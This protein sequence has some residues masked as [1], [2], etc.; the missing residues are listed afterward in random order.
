MAGI[1]PMRFDELFE[2]INVLDK[3]PGK[4]GKGDSF[5]LNLAIPA[6]KALLP[7]LQ[8]RKV[9]LLGQRVSHAFDVGQPILEWHERGFGWW[10]NDVIV[11]LSC[12]LAVCPHPS[13]VNTWWNKPENRIA[14]RVFWG[15]LAF[16]RQQLQ[17]AEFC[18][19]KLGEAK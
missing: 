7:K 13:G 10:E 5:P 12:A 6:D 19:P 17:M 15:E 8:G 4:Q 1:T 11:Q 9:V 2:C 16:E 18:D 14:A 3:W